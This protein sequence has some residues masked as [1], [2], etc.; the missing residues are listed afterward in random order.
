M[1]SG[2]KCAPRAEGEQLHGPGLS[3]WETARPSH[4]PLTPFR[5]RKAA[6]ALLRQ[7][8]RDTGQ[9]RD[10]GDVNSRM[11]SYRGSVVFSE[12]LRR[13]MFVVC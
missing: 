7:N 8:D 11:L 1:P 10:A 9:P 2:S 3:P 12:I 13:Y 5:S 4:Y 6:V